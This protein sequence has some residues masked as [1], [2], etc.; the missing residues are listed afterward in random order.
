MTFLHAKRYILHPVNYTY[1]IHWIV[2]S[3]IG[4][5]EYGTVFNVAHNRKHA[6]KLVKSVCSRTSYNTMKEIRIWT[7]AEVL[8]VAPKLVEYYRHDSKSPEGEY[9]IIVMEKLDMTLEEAL[10]LAEEENHV[11]LQELLFFRSR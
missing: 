8:G 4:S 11:A 7:Q 10:R 6:I 3:V 5:G 1:T 9:F 2:D